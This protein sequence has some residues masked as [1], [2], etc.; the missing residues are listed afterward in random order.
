MIMTQALGWALVDSLWQDALAAAGLAALLALVPVRAARTRYALATLTLMLMLALPLA[1]AARLS[2]TSPLTSDVV[3]A[4]S[5]VAPGP[6]PGA[7]PR[8]ASAVPTPAAPVAARIRSALEPALPWVVLVWFGGVVALSLRLMSGWLVTRQLGRVG[9]SSVPDAC[10][11]AVARLAARLRIS[12]PVRVLESAVVQV[13]AVIGWLRPVILLPASALTGLTPLQL[14]ALLAH[15]LAHV[16]RYDYLVNLIQAV[17][18]TLLFYHPAVWWV[19]QQIREEREHC[20]DDLAVAVCGDAHFYATALLGME[21]LRVATPVFALAAAGRGS[22][23]GRI[24][25]LVAPVQTEI[26][27]LWM[28]GVVAVSLALGGGARLAAGTA[29]LGHW[30]PLP[31]SP[32]S[33]VGRIEALRD[34]DQ[35][36]AVV[37]ALGKRGDARL[38]APL[39]AIARGDPDEGVQR[40]AVEAL[41]H[42]KDRAAADTIVDI[43]RTHPRAKVRNEAVKYIDHVLAADA[44]PPVLEEIVRRDADIH[45]QHEAIEALGQLHDTQALASLARLARTHPSVEV[46]EETVEQ[47]AKRAAPESALVLLTD[48][49]AH[50]RSSAVQVEAVQRLAALPVGMGV[51]ALREAARAH[52]SR[53]VRTEAR[54]RL[55]EGSQ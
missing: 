8:A 33:R 9:T 35:R 13:P 47:Y 28:A 17:I 24:R 54:R 18:E 10:R 36:H 44:V 15:E 23:M 43:A 20:C 3:T 55:Q 31:A 6:T 52:A 14:D 21:R 49:L 29:A 26:F 46:R 38:L 41:S 19:S 42:I 37:K 5:P 53:D 45:V 48:R 51:P 7:G 40:E 50:D 2:G 25:R 11:E 30:R 32:D 22:L 16:R 1:T 12:R 27:P 39:S 34:P 4:T